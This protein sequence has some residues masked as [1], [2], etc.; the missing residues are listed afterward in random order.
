VAGVEEDPVLRGVEDP[1]QGQRQLDHAQVGTKVT[2]GARDLRDEEV[3]D[4]RGKHVELLGGEVAEIT[5]A[6]D[7]A[8]QGRGRDLFCAHD[9]RV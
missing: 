9:R 3:A 4:L 1:V 5:G 2:A 6:A 7:R 8:Q